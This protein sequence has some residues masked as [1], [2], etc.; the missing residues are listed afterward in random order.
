MLV[1]VADVGKNSMVLLQLFWSDKGVRIVVTIPIVVTIT[2]NVTRSQTV[3]P[4][5]KVRGYYSET[6][7]WT[8]FPSLNT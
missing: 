8:S 5:S 7:D 4:S 3:L 2:E 1:S 6:Q